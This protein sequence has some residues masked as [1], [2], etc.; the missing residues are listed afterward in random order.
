MDEYIEK[1]RRKLKDR[2]IRFISR[3]I[4][5]PYRTLLDFAKSRTIGTSIQNFRKLEKY[6]EEN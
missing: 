2:N 1:V 4:D 5:I 3:E 6:F